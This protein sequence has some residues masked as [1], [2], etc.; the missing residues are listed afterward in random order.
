MSVTR[1]PAWAKGMQ[2]LGPGI[3]VTPGRELHISESEICEHFGV[4]YSRANVRMIEE[5]LVEVLRREFHIDTP[6]RFVG[7]EPPR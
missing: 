4:P 7:D 5:S 2:K 3:Y 1:T 6:A